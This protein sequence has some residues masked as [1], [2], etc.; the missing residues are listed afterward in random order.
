[1]NKYVVFMNATYQIYL[2]YTGIYF[3][4]LDESLIINCTKTQKLQEK[5]TK[6]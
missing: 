5:K 3:E 2:D 4:Y 6:L 1:M